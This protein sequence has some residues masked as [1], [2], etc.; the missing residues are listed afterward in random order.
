MSKHSVLIPFDSDRYDT[1]INQTGVSHYLLPSP[2][3]H[4]A[5][6]DAIL[7]SG[8]DI[9]M[10]LCS[11]LTTSEYAKL[12][13]F[14]R[15]SNCFET[16]FYTKTAVFN[17]D[18]QIRD[19]KIHT[20]LSEME[21]GR[22]IMV[23]HTTDKAPEHPAWLPN[24]HYSNPWTGY[25]GSKMFIYDPKDKTERYLGIPVQRET[26]YG[27][28]Y[29]E[30][31]GCYYALG[32]LK[33]HLYKINPQTMEVKDYG[34]IVERASYRL[35]IAGDQNIYFSSRNGVLLRLNIKEDKVENL[36][37]QLPHDQKTLNLKKGYI[38]FMTNGPD[39]MLYIAT[40]FTDRIVRFDPKNGTLEELGR[41]KNTKYYTDGVKGF[42]HVGAMGF[43]KLGVLYI[44]VCPIRSDGRENFKMGAS[45]IRWDVLNQKEPEF[46]GILGSET[47]AVVTSCSM[48][49]DHVT[50]EM[51][52]IQ[53]NH[54]ND[55]P[56]ILKIDLSA[57]R[58]MAH[59]SGPKCL[60]P[61]INPSNNAYEE[62][63]KSIVSTLNAWASNPY[64]CMSDRVLPIA[65]WKD[66]KLDPGSVHIQKVRVENTVHVQ[67]S[68]GQFAIYTLEGA[69]I[70]KGVMSE[71]EIF[72][73]VASVDGFKLP[74]TYPGRQY[75]STKR[76]VM[77]F[78]TG[79]KVMVTHDGLLVLEKLDKTYR[80]YGP[81]WINAQLTA[82]LR[83]NRRDVIYGVAG[84]RD[85]FSCVFRFSVDTGIEWLGFLGSESI[86]HGAFNSPQGGSIAVDSRDKYLVIASNTTLPCVYIYKLGGNYDKNK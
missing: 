86:E 16:C 37:L 17:N 6:W 84:D 71:L 32:F 5:S 80:N 56:D 22:L 48:L 40:Q 70:E 78:K 15:D 85:D 11:E 4:N 18:R 50:D 12:T 69:L 31:T 20:A 23:T 36:N 27:G 68:D 46:L 67:L 24:A 35:H 8:R 44:T 14:N 29:S 7:T 47:R 73:R 30:I 65:V 57:Y 79:E 21:D 9:Y 74:F 25:A 45:L 58:D 10:S 76:D 59:V 52:I 82:W 3:V 26:L 49:M 60:D 75:L 34:Q 42:D 64:Y 53:T 19:S 62:H 54:G 2:S 39:G 61:Y 28:V 33:G 63:D 38:C 81:V 41:Y 55:A 13:H 43:D 83:L 51:F 1:L 77:N 66:L 72:E